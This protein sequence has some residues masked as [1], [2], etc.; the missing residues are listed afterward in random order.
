MEEVFGFRALKK[1]DAIR[2]EGE[3]EGNDEA[4]VGDN[5]LFTE[6]GANDGIAKE[7][8]IVEDEGELGLGGKGFLPEGAVENKFGKK[9]EAEHHDKTSEEAK[10]EEVEEVGIGGGGKS[11]EKRGGHKD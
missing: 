1:P 8:G 6:G 9:N 11:R 2:E 7:G 3:I 10:K 4:T 5:S